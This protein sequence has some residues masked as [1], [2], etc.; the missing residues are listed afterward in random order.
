MHGKVSVC[1]CNE[2]LFFQMTTVLRKI[3]HLL[4]KRGANEDDIRHTRTDDVSEDTGNVVTSD[5]DEDDTRCEVLVINS[6]TIQNLYEAHVS[7]G[8]FPFG[9]SVY[10]QR[11][12]PNYVSS[13]PFWYFLQLPQ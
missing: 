6:Q 5:D 12:L 10:G 8:V 1:V 4:T 2:S 7:P 11:V 13:A 3:K 9:Q